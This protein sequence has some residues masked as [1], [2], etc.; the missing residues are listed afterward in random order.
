MTKK[1]RPKRKSS[2]RPAQANDTQDRLLRAA[3]LEF[4]A[5][6]YREHGST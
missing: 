3:E 2:D 6:G 1:P 4:A 5:Q